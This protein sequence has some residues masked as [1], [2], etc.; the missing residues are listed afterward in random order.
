MILDIA[1]DSKSSQESINSVLDVSLKL[2]EQFE[3]L[4]L[5][6]TDRSCSELLPV[7]YSIPG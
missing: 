5:R 3:Y 7:N 1:D 6:M 2:E 4:W